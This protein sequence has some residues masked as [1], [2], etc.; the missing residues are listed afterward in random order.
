MN[1]KKTR[2]LSKLISFMYTANIPEAT[3]GTLKIGRSNLELD[4]NGGFR[5][6]SIFFNGAIYIYNNL[7]DGYG[8]KMNDSSITITNF[9]LKNLKNNKVLFDYDGDLEVLKANIIT[10]GGKQINLKIDNVN[11]AEFID[12][13]KT[14]F[15]DNSLLFLEELT[16]LDVMPIKKG[17]GD[18]SV[19]GLFAHK[20]LADG[21]TGDYNYHPKESVYMTGKTITPQSQPI[22]KPVSSFK[23]SKNK[24]NL[25]NIYRKKLKTFS[26]VGETRTTN[27]VEMKPKTIQQKTSEEKTETRE[28]RRKTRGTGGSY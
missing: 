24:V 2:A 21:Y 10:I 13:S 11:V 15:E 1:L 19:R 12:N 6:L 9:L 23:L 26:E 20:P 14:N 28:P 17:I 22:G 3:E 7:P 25:E 5:R 16:P 18:D 8:I 4:I 27:Q